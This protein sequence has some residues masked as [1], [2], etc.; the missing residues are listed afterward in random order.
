MVWLHW[1]FRMTSDS[2]AHHAQTQKVFHLFFFSSSFPPP[3]PP[4]GA[5]FLNTCLDHEVEVLSA[6]CHGCIWF[7]RWHQTAEFVINKG[8]SYISLWPQRG[9]LRAYTNVWKILM[10]KVLVIEAQKAAGGNLWD[11]QSKGI[12]PF[13]ISHRYQAWYGLAV[14]VLYILPTIW[15]FDIYE[16]IF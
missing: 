4:P 7:S 8:P 9:Q 6:R 11:W 13:M 3:P 1:V 10:Q 2:E 12:V 14:K 5:A 15:L 16:F